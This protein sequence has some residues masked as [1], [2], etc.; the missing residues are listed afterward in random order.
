MTGK[1]IT[2]ASVVVKWF[3]SESEEKKNHETATQLYSLLQKNTLEIWA[4]S[5]LLIELSNVFLQKKHLSAEIVQQV[6]QKLQHS[7]IQ[8]IDFDHEDT[9]ELV[10]LAD[11]YKLTSYDSLYLLLAKQKNLPLLTANKQLL[12]VKGI[13]F[14]LDEWEEDNII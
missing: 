14:S 3:S 12:G 4:P 1:I 13:C 5:F 2:D 6:I 8:F 11:H 10:F 9:P 7:G